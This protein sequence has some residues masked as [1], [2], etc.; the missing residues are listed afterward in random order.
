MA[1]YGDTLNQTFPGVSSN[2]DGELHRTFHTPSNNTKSAGFTF[3]QQFLFDN[4][5][6]SITYQPPTVSCQQMTTEHLD[7]LCYSPKPSF[8][9]RFT[10]QPQQQFSSLPNNRLNPFRAFL[11][12]NRLTSS[13]V[14]VNR[15]ACEY[16]WYT[17]NELK[18]KTIEN[19]IVDEKSLSVV[20][21]SF[22]S[23]QS[24]LTKI[25]AGKI[26]YVLLG[27]G[28]RARFSLFIQD[29]DN[30]QVPLRFYGFEPIHIMQ[31]DITCD[32]QGLILSSDHYFSILFHNTM[33]D[34]NH[35]NENQH[36]GDFIP[37]LKDKLKFKQL[38]THR[39]Y[40]TTGLLNSE[41]NL[42]IPLMLNILKSNED[43]IQLNI[44][45][46][47]NISGL[48]MLDE[49]YS[50]R[51]YNPYFIQCLLGYRSLDLINHNITEIIP[52][53]NELNGTQSNNLS[54]STNNDH[55]EEN[56]SCQSLIGDDEPSTSD[57][58][59]NTLNDSSIDNTPK[60]ARIFNSIE[61]KIINEKLQSNILPI[62]KRLPTN[63]ISSFKTTSTPVTKSA[64]KSEIK[65]DSDDQAVFL[66]TIGKHKNGTCIGVTYTLR[67]LDLPDGTYRYCMWLS[68][69][70]TDPHLIEM[71][72]LLDHNQSIIPIDDLSTSFLNVSSS[73]NDNQTFDSK[74]II[75]RQ[76]GR[77]G[78]GQVYL[79]HEKSNE[80][81]KVVIKFI[82]KTKIKLHRYVESFEPKKRILFEVA[83][84]KQL[85]HRNIVEILDAFDTDNYV[86]MIMPLHG[87]G[88][89]LYEFIEKGAKIDESLA[90]YI[91]RQVVDAVS[92]LHRNHIAHQDIKDEN[93]II[94]E[95]F[96]IKLIDFGSAISIT[97]ADMYTSNFGGTTEFCCPEFFQ[98]GSCQPYVADIWAM[99][100]TLYVII[101]RR[102]PFLNPDEIKRCQ[103]DIKFLQ[104]RI[105][106]E[107]YDLITSTLIRQPYH[108]LTMYEIEKHEWILQP[109]N[110]EF[111]SWNTVTQN[112]LEETFLTGNH[113]PSGDDD[114][115]NDHSFASL[116]RQIQNQFHLFEKTK[117]DNQSDKNNL[118]AY[119]NCKHASI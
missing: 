19:L 90:S 51:A 41:K 83:V 17:E 21:D 73:L 91:F 88:I 54:I 32:K 111:Y 89:D 27:T 38:L 96:H 105:S 31:A 4:A 82:K 76:R 45:I 65:I 68:R 58:S 35:L 26:V 93:L 42:F 14:S 52:D 69:D 72:K 24:G 66:Q 92:Y 115:S 36:I 8:S 80:S 39:T 15:Q 59:S 43:N 23:Q 7:R 48:I 47:S 13:I 3:E 57:G 75:T 11:I 119:L 44:S 46:M 113:L 16:F 114:N 20:T 106:D 2:E 33:I 25:L 1:T 110:S 50:I 78:Y 84:L 77:G 55:D 64:I 107:L 61:N 117:K 86:Q 53:F 9:P 5:C 71:Q 12:V 97:Q 109:F 56:L 101:F 30:D 79:G 81:N 108:R 60:S 29:L 100:V 67:R 63:G 28:E 94:D 49:T 10:S 40:R 116:T 6:H 37:S 95:Q 85:K 74:Y 102:Y 98:T 99:M 34:N 104:S 18:N 62:D 70:N 103:L 112:S 118:F 87:Q 22:L